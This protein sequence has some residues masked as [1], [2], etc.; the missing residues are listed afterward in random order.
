MERNIVD[1]KITGKNATNIFNTIIREGLISSQQHAAY[2]GKELYKAEIAI[3]YNL[4]YVQDKEL[5][6]KK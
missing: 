2:L 1:A 4:N 6:F 5:R 3:N